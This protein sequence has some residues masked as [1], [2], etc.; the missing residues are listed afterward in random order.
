MILNQLPKITNQ[1]AEMFSNILQKSVTS[2]VNNNNQQ[3]TSGQSP[4]PIKDENRQQYQRTKRLRSEEKSESPSSTV[5]NNNNIEHLDKLRKNNSLPP[6]KE[7]HLSS[8]QLKDIQ[9]SI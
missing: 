1:Q 3:E 8:E 5:N 6:I 9:I 7:E 4:P 2:I